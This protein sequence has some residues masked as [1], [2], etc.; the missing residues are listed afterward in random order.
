MTDPPAPPI[1]LP[2]PAATEALG[3]R[4][5]ALLRPGDVVALHG[6]LG[7]GKT[8]LARGLIRAL[9]GADTEVP[10][11][12][13]TLVQSYPTPEL[14]LVHADLYRLESVAES[15]ELGLEDAFASAA[16][17]IEWPERL[18]SRLP[19]D[20]LDVHLEDAGDGG[21]T[22]RLIGRGAWRER[23]SEL[24]ADE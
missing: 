15:V 6:G 13:F 1:P 17:V 11:P 7:A 3:A 22:A 21:R 2:T 23:I 8:T 9:A 10:S 4:I 24:G 20:R 19:G 14:D 12:T 5:A 16:T 18:G